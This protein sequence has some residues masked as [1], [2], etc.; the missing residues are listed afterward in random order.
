MVAAAA[1]VV[2]A[3]V[4]QRVRIASSPSHRFTLTVACASRET[5]A[6]QEKRENEKIVLLDLENFIF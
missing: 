6:F 3:L 1:A 5:R 2:V 4:E